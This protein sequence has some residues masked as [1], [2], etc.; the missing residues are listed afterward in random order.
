RLVAELRGALRSPAGAWQPLARRL[1]EQRLAP[2]AKHLA[3]VRRLV[4]L[5][6]SALAGVPVEVFADGYTVSY[7]L[8]GTIAAHLRRRPGPATQGLLALA[9]P[10]FKAPAGR[11][12]DGTW[13]ALPGTRAE[14]E[15]LRRLFPKAPAPRL[16]LGS[17]ASEQHLARLAQ[18]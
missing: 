7:G 8:S 3:G 14:V 18:E 17:E 12:R 11:S 13:R 16:L 10:V 2:L 9:D 15:A 1:R 4:M 5:P 6:S